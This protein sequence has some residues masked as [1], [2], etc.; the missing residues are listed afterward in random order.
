VGRAMSSAQQPPWRLLA[1]MMVHLVCVLRFPA[2]ASDFYCS[3]KVSFFWPPLLRSLFSSQS[4]VQ[5]PPSQPWPL[6]L[7]FLCLVG[8]L[9]CVLRGP[10]P[11]IGGG[12]S[13]GGG[14]TG[15]QDMV[16]LRL[17]IFPS[18]SF[19]LVS[20]LL[21]SSFCGFFLGGQQ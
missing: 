10:K 18:F 11:S 9:L 8:P 20:S 17:F 3:H 14:N 19:S 6:C 15:T 16:A 4:Y 5:S 12:S 13:R 1:P 7:V 21:V 2:S